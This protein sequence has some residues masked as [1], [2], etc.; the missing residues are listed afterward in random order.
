MTTTKGE[1]MTELTE[2]ETF[3]T[4]GITF[5][6]MLFDGRPVAARTAKGNL[7]N[8]CKRCGGSGQYSFNLQDGTM[9]YGCNGAGVSGQTTEADV[10]RKAVNRA[11]AAAKRAEKAKAER[12]A[13]NAVMD[14][15]KA[16]NADLLAALAPYLP[17]VK[18]DEYNQPYTAERH[19][20]SFLVDMAEKAHG[21]R[22]LSERQV[23]A[24]R[25]ALRTQAERDAQKAQ[26]AAQQVAAG[27]FAQ[28]SAKVN[29]TVTITKVKFIPS[30]RW[31]RASSYLVKM[32]TEEG[33]VLSTFNSGDFGRE[34]E[35]G[36]V[37][38]IKGTV[39]AHTEYDGKPETQL[40]RV[41]KQK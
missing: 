33:H 25:N 26:E 29:V 19:W 21:Y 41:T 30:E 13:A 24:A 5:T 22:P 18:V 23:E 16:A 1:T 38:K 34:A 31:D 15:W 8:F 7:Y 37:V 3:T 12:D 9:C 39:K 32:E 4:R 10:I 14:A 35:E 11:K 28:V 2:G 20:N 36:Q 17:V 40:T 6:E 27:H